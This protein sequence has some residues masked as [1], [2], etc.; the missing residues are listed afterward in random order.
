ML[1]G[2]AD[3]RYNTPGGIAAS[4]DTFNSSNKLAGYVTLQKLEGVRRSDF[5]ME[6]KTVTTTDM[7]LPIS[8]HVVCY[9]KATE[10]WFDAEDP[11]DALNQA[12]AFSDDITI[13]YDKA[14]E[15]GGKVRLVVVE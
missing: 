7:V 11:M 13:Y 6:A 12:R 1:Y 10:N 15:D 8:E 9:N 2:S 14:P 5:D 3:V 4:L